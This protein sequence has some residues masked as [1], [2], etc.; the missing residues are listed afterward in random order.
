MLAASPVY[1]CF[2]WRIGRSVEDVYAQVSALVV[3]MSEAVREPHDWSMQGRS[4]FAWK[5]ECA[6]SAWRVRGVLT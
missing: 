4:S 2:K 6:R 1:F 5:P 3:S